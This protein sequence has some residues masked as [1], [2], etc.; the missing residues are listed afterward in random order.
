MF[1]PNEVTYEILSNIYI[2][3]SEFNIFKVQR[4]QNKQNYE[5]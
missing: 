3:F 1:L 4:Q 5:F 2:S